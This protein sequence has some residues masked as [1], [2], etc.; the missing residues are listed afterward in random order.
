MRLLLRCSLKPEAPVT[1]APGSIR[2]PRTTPESFS[3]GRNWCWQLEHIYPECFVEGLTKEGFSHRVDDCVE[4]GKA[5]CVGGV[6]TRCGTG[7]K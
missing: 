4:V 6:L 1:G 7:F 5:F 3:A 2:G